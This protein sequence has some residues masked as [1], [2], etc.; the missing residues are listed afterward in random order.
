MGFYYDVLRLPDGRARRLKV[1][2]IV[3]L[4]PV[5]AVTVARAVAAANGVPEPVK[6][7][8]ERLRRMPELLDSIHATGPGH[9]GGTVASWAW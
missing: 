3:G 9:S 4:L 8:T 6:T 7:F 1:R 2:S 5:C